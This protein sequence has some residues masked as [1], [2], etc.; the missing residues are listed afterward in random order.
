MFLCQQ[1]L[2]WF[3]YGLLRNTGLGGVFVLG[4]EIKLFVESIEVML[5][6]GVFIGC[7]VSS[8]LCASVESRCIFSAYVS[9]KRGILNDVH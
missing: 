3:A 2:V 9:R 7:W 6:F 8:Y 4:K 5:V 1:E